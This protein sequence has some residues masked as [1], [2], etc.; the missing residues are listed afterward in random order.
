MYLEVID[1]NTTHTHMKK[2]FYYS[3]AFLVVCTFLTHAQSNLPSPDA[4]QNYYIGFFKRGEAWTA[5]QTEEVKSNQAGHLKNLERMFWLGKLLGAGPFLDDSD[6]RGVLI[7]KDD[8]PDTLR[9]L[10]ANDPAVKAKRLIVNLYPWWGQKNIGKELGDALQQDPTMKYEME[11]YQFVILKQGPKWSPDTTPELEKLQEE[12]L[13][14]IMHLLKEKKALV[15][16][17]FKNK[18]VFRGILIFKEKS[19]EDARAIAE[20]DP[21]VKAGH[22]Q[23][24]IHPWM[25]AKG[26]IPE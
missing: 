18:D 3:Y 20:S 17:P 15:A 5:E 24:E 21:A 19:L 8:A 25:C 4:M 13:A 9:A 6:L 26:V 14:H 12:H 16:G 2:I 7:F 10:I 11:R 1:S 23:V 22:L